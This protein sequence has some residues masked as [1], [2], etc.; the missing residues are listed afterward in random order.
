MYVSSIQV[1]GASVLSNFLLSTDL[2]I[3]LPRSVGPP[4]A[5]ELFVGLRM[6]VEG[7]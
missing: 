7:S 6:S 3:L 5:D 2:S 4:L 1:Y